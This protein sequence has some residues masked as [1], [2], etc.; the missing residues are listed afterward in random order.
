MSSSTTYISTHTHLYL[1]SNCFYT[2]FGDY[3]IHRL[4][5]AHLCLTLRA[6]YFLLPYTVSL[7]IPQL[8]FIMNLILNFPSNFYQVLQAAI[9]VSLICC[10]QKC[11]L[12][13]YDKIIQNGHHHLACHW[14]YRLHTQVLFT[15]CL[16]V[17]LLKPLIYMSSNVFHTDI[18]YLQQRP[19]PS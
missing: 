17:M 16:S 4:T 6:K 9:R 8:H 1:H 12:L 14:C 7:H 3:T 18:T 11:L 10:S 15:D 19:P 13:I 5:N 2:F